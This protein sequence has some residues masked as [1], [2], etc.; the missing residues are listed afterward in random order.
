MGYKIPMGGITEME[1]WSWDG[2]K[3]HPETPLPR[4]PSHIQQP[5]ADTIAYAS[6]ILLTRP[7]YSSLLWSYASAWQIQKWMLTV[8]YWM[9]HR[10]PKE[11]ARK[12]TQGSKGVC[13]PIGGITIWTNQ[14]PTELVSLAAYV[15]EDGP[16]QPSVGGEVLGLVKIICLSTGECQGQEAGVGGLG[17]RVGGWYRGLSDSIWNVNEESI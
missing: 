5:N 10:A 17:S 8:I 7:W 3:N 12:S 9:E 6:K 15:A 4:V 11:G 13:N 16:S 2:R 14:Y 1:V